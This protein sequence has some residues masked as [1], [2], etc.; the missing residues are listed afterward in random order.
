[1]NSNEFNKSREELFDICK[2]ITDKKGRDYTKGSHDVLSHFS[3]SAESFGMTKYQNLGTFLKKHVDAI[4][5]YI[6]SNGQSESEPIQS[7]I[8]DAIN[9]LTFFNA[10]VLEDNNSIPKI[11]EPVISQLFR[12]EGADSYTNKIVELFNERIAYKQLD[13]SKHTNDVITSMQGEKNW[14]FQAKVGSYKSN[15]LLEVVNANLSKYFNLLKNSI[16]D[17]K[18]SRTDFRVLNTPGI[19]TIKLYTVDDIS[20]SIKNEL[21]STTSKKLIDGTNLTIPS[22]FSVEL[23][24]IRSIDDHISQGT[25][26]LVGLGDSNFIGL[27]SNAGYKDELFNESV[28]EFSELNM[29]KR[30]FFNIN[31]GTNVED[32]YTEPANKT[33]VV[34]YIGLSRLDK[35]PL[36]KYYFE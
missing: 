10:M 6:K 9:F 30:I 26:M 31:N 15:D 1:M 36:F 35:S 2:G 19:S 7:R 21:L 20:H 5:N 33:N 22:N 18:V 25:K 16:V 29:N 4:Y 11:E 34:E 14:L 24:L 12:I 32:I 28:K 3:E 27:S 17:V 13:I 8:A 23:T